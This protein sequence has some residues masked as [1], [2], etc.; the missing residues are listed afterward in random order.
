M[1]GLCLNPQPK[2]A[3]VLGFVLSLI[4]WGKVEALLDSLKKLTL[5]PHSI[6]S[7]LHSHDQVSAFT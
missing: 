3:V 1:S 5:A 4:P 7:E 2:A 6:G